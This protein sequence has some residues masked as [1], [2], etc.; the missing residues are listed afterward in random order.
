VILTS[1]RVMTLAYFFS[2]KPLFDGFPA[3]PY[4][5]YFLRKEIMEATL[6]CVCWV[7]PQLDRAPKCLI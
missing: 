4:I 7:A 5:F 6:L 1:K 3:L 2:H